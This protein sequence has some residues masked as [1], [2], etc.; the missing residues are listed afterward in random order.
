M[1]KQMEIIIERKNKYKPPA[2]RVPGRRGWFKYPFRYMEV[3]HTFTVSAVLAERV[4]SAACQY[5]KDN[6]GRVIEVHR[7]DDNTIRVFRTK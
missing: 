5:C 7:V 1:N 6:K 2:G 4:R 3:G